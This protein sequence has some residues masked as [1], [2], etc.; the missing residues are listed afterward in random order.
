M[1]WE[2]FHSPLFRDSSGFQ[3]LVS[4]KPASKH[5]TAASAITRNH[6]EC[7]PNIQNQSEPITRAGCFDCWRSNTI[8]MG[9]NRRHKG[10]KPQ[11]LNGTA[12]GP[13]MG[14]T[15]KKKST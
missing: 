13:D 15:N 7:P 14:K 6:Q 8:Q 10:Q 1:S 5:I 4:H 2:S 12:G 3:D 11:S 9:A